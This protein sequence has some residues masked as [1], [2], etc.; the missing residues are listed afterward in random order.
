MRRVLLTL[1]F[2]FLTGSLIAGEIVPPEEKIALLSDGQYV[3]LVDTLNDVSRQYGESGNLAAPAFNTIAQTGVPGAEIEAPASRD[4]FREI[5]SAARAADRGNEL[6]RELASIK[7]NLKENPDKND[8]EMRRKLEGFFTQYEDQ[9]NEISL[10]EPEF[11]NQ[12]LQRFQSFD[13][14]HRLYRALQSAVKETAPAA[15][16]GESNSPSDRGSRETH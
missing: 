10:R 6:D 9:L 12:S 5:M 7:K 15:R 4:S 1:V 14:P 8:W 16:A 3:P 11:A 2:F 13:P